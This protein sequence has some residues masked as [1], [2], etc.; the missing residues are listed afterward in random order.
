VGD[1][2]NGGDEPCG[3]DLPHG[4]NRRRHIFLACQAT[5]FR[6]SLTMSRVV[7][8]IVRP[9]SL[10]HI[11]QVCGSWTIKNLVNAKLRPGLA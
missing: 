10:T 3:L 8:P 9:P 6:Y 4:L 11:A 1:S 2:G 5:A 7:E